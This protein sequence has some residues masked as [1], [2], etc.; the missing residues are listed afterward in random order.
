MLTKATKIIFFFV[1]IS[2]SSILSSTTSLASAKITAREQKQHELEIQQQKSNTKIDVI[3][4]N[5]ITKTKVEL[6]YESLCPYSRAFFVDQLEPTYQKLV[7]Y[8]D[9]EVIPYGNV[10]VNQ[11]VGGSPVFICQ[12][13]AAE[14]YGN[15][16]QACV[17]DY[18][19]N[20]TA[21]SLEYVR[22]MFA[23]GNQQNPVPGIDSNWKNTYTNAEACANVQF[24]Q[25]IWPTITECTGGPLGQELIIRNWQRTA[26]LIP[27]HSYVP[28][29]VIEGVHTEEL[30]NEA[31][32]ALLSYLCSNYLTDNNVAACQ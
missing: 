5:R 6:Y 9:V 19:A 32:D 28:W 11:S 20:A 26:N 16:V 22:C 13:G 12:H 27:K 21:A 15:R 4:Q 25:Q 10:R 2:F 24:G 14:C 1:Y 8:I 31:Q 23:P 29:I 17:I 7:D 30:Q 3:I 18:L